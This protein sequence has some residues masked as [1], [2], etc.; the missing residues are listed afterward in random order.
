M[1][2]ET[3]KALALD[4]DLEL[5]PAT[6]AHVDCENVEIQSAFDT[7]LLEA[8]SKSSS[9][10]YQLEHSSREKRREASKKLLASM[11]RGID[12][13]GWKFNRDELYD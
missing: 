9:I 3:G 10:L 5:A 1:L 6:N 11:D 12:F 4:R 7:W 8:A 2:E 13:Q